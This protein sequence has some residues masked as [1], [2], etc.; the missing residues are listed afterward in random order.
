MWGLGQQQPEHA[1]A[2][3]GDQQEIVDQHAERAAAPAGPCIHGTARDPGGV[4]HQP[5]R[6]RHCD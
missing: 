2:V 3:D 4:Q 5:G 6:I 1:D